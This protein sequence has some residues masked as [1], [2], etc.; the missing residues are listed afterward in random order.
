MNEF[1]FIKIKYEVYFEDDLFVVCCLNIDVVSDGVI[2]E[3]VFDN[4]CEVIELYFE[5][6]VEVVI[7]L[8]EV[9]GDVDD[10]DDEE[11]EEDWQ[12]L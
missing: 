5:C 12:V 7:D 1:K 4:L 3:E 9:Q 2:E 10:E 6:N 11:V 8:V